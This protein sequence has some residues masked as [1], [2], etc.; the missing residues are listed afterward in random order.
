[1]PRNDAK[2]PS[3]RDVLRATTGGFLLGATGV[4]LRFAGVAKAKSG[5]QRYIVTANPN[6]V[7]RIENAG[8]EVINSLADDEV[9]IVAGPEADQD[10][11]KNVTGVQHVAQDIK[12]ELENTAHDVTEF[13]TGSSNF[14]GEGSESPTLGDFQWEKRLM[15]IPEAHAIATGAGAKI[16]IIDTGVQLGHPDLG[17]L[18]EEESLAFIDGERIGDSEPIDVFGHGTMVAG[19]AAAQGKGVLGTAPDAELIS[20]RVFSASGS[21]TFV[22]I[23]LA[24]EYAADINADV[25]NV[26]LGTVPLPPQ[27]NAGGLRAADERIANRAVRDGTIVVYAAGNSGTNLQQ[28]GQFVLAAS[29]AGTVAASATGADDELTFY[30]N[31]GTNVIDVAAPGGGMADFVESYCGYAEYIAQFDP[32][33]PDFPDG[34]FK[35]FIAPEDREIPES[36]L[37][38]S[39]CFAAPD[40]VFP[41]PTINENFIQ[42]CF[43]CTTPEYPF[44]TNGIISTAYLPAL[45]LYTYEWEGGTSFAAPHVAG[46]IALVR[47]LQPDMNPRRVVDRIK[48]SADG[49]SGRSDPEFGAGRINALNT[50]KRVS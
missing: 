47:E 8:F 21:T 32:V 42:K 40:Q 50:V 16:A 24:T 7:S 35:E 31:Y 41:L 11:L 4:S 15:G 6:A 33:N 27:A 19:I 39:V 14:S 12:I 23:L 3:R 25:A 22:D 44:P 48:Q 38:T 46:L 36:G 45:N 49:A 20:I 28:G 18:N 2:K 1:M 10:D 34:P 9:L 26:S 43:D 37:E 13:E 30:S 17:N 29:V 5:D